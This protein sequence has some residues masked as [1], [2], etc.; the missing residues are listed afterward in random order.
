MR[1]SVP[2]KIARG[3][4][5]PSTVS[6]VRSSGWVFRT[7]F[8]P[9][10]G[11]EFVRHC[12]AQIL[13]VDLCGQAARLESPVRFFEAKEEISQGL[14]GDPQGRP[15]VYVSGG[16]GK[17]KTRAE[18]VHGFAPF[19]SFL[20]LPESS[21]RPGNAGEQHERRHSLGQQPVKNTYARGPVAP[22]EVVD[23]VVRFV[24]GR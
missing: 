13:Q 10:L 8:F 5:R 23:Q 19:K 16:K 15:S 7:Q 4:L 17:T 14:P 18:S 20:H 3:F 24:L 9:P 21:E 6:S 1:R 11:P 2:N 22:Q 12:P